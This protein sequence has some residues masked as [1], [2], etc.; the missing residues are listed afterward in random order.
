[1]DGR[2]AAAT[3]GV[4]P[5]ATRDEIRRAFRARVKRVHPD[6][7]T[8]GS[9]DDF[10][11]V[12]QAFERL[13]ADAP[14]PPLTGQVHRRQ[15]GP[16][17]TDPDPGPTLDLTDVGRRPAPAAQRAAATGQAPPEAGHELRAQAFHRH[18]TDAL[19]RTP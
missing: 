16:W 9:A 5:H 10:I 6:T 3:L 18:L 7:G 4:D 1:M 17:S 15:D 2:T 8:H 11:A 13:L 19:A 12:R 14:L